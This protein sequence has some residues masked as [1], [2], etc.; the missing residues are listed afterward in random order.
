MSKITF[1]TGIPTM[2]VRILCSS[3]GEDGKTYEYSGYFLRSFEN[4]DVVIRDD[5]LGV[6]RLRQNALR[7]MSRDALFRMFWQKAFAKT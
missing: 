5:K 6:L 1:S 2:A 7:Q 3:V 4:G